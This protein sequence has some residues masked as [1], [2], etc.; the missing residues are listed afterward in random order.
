MGGIGLTTEQHG[1]PGFNL[2]PLTKSA[3]DTK[4]LELQK[5]SA[6]VYGAILPDPDLQDSLAEAAL[7]DSANGSIFTHDNTS[8]RLLKPIS[9]AFEKGNSLIFPCASIN[10]LLSRLCTHFTW[11]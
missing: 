11:R 9:E 6:D 2:M 8:H 5:H 7:H 4:I 3:T 1:A 10:K